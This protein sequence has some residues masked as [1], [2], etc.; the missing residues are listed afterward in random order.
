MARS[1]SGGILPDLEKRTARLPVRKAPAPKVVHLPMKQHFGTDAIP[2]VKVGDRVLKGQKIGEAGEGISCPVHS[3]ISG[4]VTAVSP[5]ASPDGESLAVTVENDFKEELSPEVRSFAVPIAKAE[6]EELILH[7]KEKGLTGH[8]GGAFPLWAKIREA[9]EKKVT[10]VIIN[11]CESEPYL[12]M[13]HRVLLEKAEEVVGGVKILLRATGAEKAIFA[14]ETNK[15]DAAE[16]LMAIVGESRSFAVAMFRTKYPQGDE[17]LLVRSVMARE[18]PTG[19][20]PTDVG[21]VV[22]NPCTAFTVYRAFV[23]GMPLVERGLTV[24][25]DCVRDPDHILVPLGTS[26]GQVLDFCGGTLAKPDVLVSGGPMTG[27]LCESEDMPVTK[28]VSAVLAMKPGE[29]REE[30]CI[31]CGRCVQVCPMK[32]VPMELCRAVRRGKRAALER[33]AAVSC[34]ECGACSWACPAGIPLVDEIRRGKAILSSE[35]K[36]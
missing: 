28:S 1:F 2:L 3:S 29:R 10:R 25:G 7:M 22:L 36:G 26:L 34:T 30:A 5:L 21:A 11:C 17:K 13:D 27:R 24:D 19:L 31:R 32:L 6:P 20:R 16:K 35:M 23:S 4:T 12:T 14:V 8:G 33:Y 18:I 9:R 15:E